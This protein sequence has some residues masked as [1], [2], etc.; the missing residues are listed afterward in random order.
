MA[1]SSVQTVVRLPEALRKAL[2]E[3]A[4]QDRDSLNSLIIKAI[5][6]YLSTSRA[7]S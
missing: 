1:A 5:E 3:R 7:S 6:A 2:D 4:W